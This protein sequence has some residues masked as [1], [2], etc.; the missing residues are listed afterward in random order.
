MKIF[1]IKFPKI[2]ALE[3]FRKSQILNTNLAN[4]KI[5]KFILI[6]AREE[7]DKVNNESFM[8]YTN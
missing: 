2:L 5:L 4:K 8:V 7:L 6:K 3:A 1:S